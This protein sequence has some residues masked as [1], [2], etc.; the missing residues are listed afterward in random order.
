MCRALTTVSAIVAWRLDSFDLVQMTVQFER[1][2]S[3]VNREKNFKFRAKSE[4]F[5]WFI[6]IVML[7]ES[8]MGFDLTEV[9]VYFI[10]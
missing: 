10:G 4:I 7:F 2:I 6:F 1:T 3:K 9:S 8:V 5:W